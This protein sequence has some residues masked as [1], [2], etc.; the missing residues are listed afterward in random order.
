MR[1]E[2]ERRSIGQFAAAQI[3]LGDAGQQRICAMEFAHG[4]EQMPCLVLSNQPRSISQGCGCRS[5][6][7]D[8]E[9]DAASRSRSRRPVRETSSREAHSEPG[10]PHQQ[11][12]PGRYVRSGENVQSRRG[13]VRLAIAD[14][15]GVEHGAAADRDDGR[16][17][18]D[19]EAVAGQQQ[20]RLAQDD[21]HVGSLAGFHHGRGA[22]QPNFRLDLSGAR[23]K[24]HRRAMLQRLGRGQQIERAIEHGASP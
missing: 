18:A 3:L 23:V 12:G 4:C 2:N 9:R 24:M 13:I 8:S 7:S 20:R 11:R 17:H 6:S 15:A 16:E 21:A 5:R 14:T 10:L 1:I 19:D 22:Q